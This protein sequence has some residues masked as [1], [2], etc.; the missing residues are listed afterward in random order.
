M[1]EAF[2]YYKCSWVARQGLVAIAPVGSNVWCPIGNVQFF[3]MARQGLVAIAPVGSNVW[4]CRRQ[5]VGKQQSTGLLHLVIRVP[6]R[7]KC[8]YP[9]GY[10]HFWWLARDS[11]PG[12]T[13]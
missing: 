7:Q 1:R 10:P 8:G 13:P 12:P 6:E 5:A 3:G 4:C 11:N 9:N 2:L